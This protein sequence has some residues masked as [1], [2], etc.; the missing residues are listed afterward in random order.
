MYGYIYI[1]TNIT[2]GKIYIGQKKSQVFLGNKYLGSGTL[3]RSAIKKYGYSNF[4]VSMLEE[5]SSKEDLD[6]KEI[7]WISKYDSMNK[8]IGY[9]ICPGGHNGNI[10]DYLPEEQ[11]LRIRKEH[12]E[13][14]K[15]FKHSEETKLRISKL[16]KGR[17]RS[18]ETRNKISQSLKGKSKKMPSSMK[19][20]K[21]EMSSNSRWIT[22]GCEDKFIRSS[23]INSYLDNGWIYGRSKAKRRNR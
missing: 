23:E 8:D 13:F 21:S 9:N 17:K 4:N 6:E 1:T 11:V 2:N 10:M 20:K 7:Y 15:T 18:E 14:M 22:N 16:H 5:C 3:I 19:E 12:S